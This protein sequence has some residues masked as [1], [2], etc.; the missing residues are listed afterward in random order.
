MDRALDGRDSLRRLAGPHCRRCA[1]PLL[2]FGR[3]LSDLRCGNRRSAVSFDRV[4]LRRNSHLVANTLRL[5]LCC[6]RSLRRLAHGT[7]AQESCQRSGEE[8]RCRG[9]R[10]A[11]GDGAT[12]SQ[13]RLRARGSSRKLRRPSPRRLRSQS[14]RIRPANKT[15][16]ERTFEARCPGEEIRKS[17]LPKKKRSAKTSRSPLAPTAPTAARPRCPA[18]PVAYKLP[19]TALLHRADEHSAINELELKNLAQVLAE[20][21]GEF[22]VRGQVVQINPGPGGNHVRVQAGSGHQVQPRHWPLR[23]PMPGFARR[24]HPDRAHGRQVNCRHPGP[25]SRARDHLAA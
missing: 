16:I 11:S 7:R 25:Q 13:T 20:K 6:S 17:V 24:E 18:W 8:A 22:D 9:Q 5:C 1:D 2:Q 15:G 19:S 14:A 23:R 3:R 21:C 12:C 4:F 10:Q